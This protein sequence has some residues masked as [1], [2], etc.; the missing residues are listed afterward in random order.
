MSPLNLT[1]KRSI[2]HLVALQQMRKVAQ[3]QAD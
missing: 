2:S 3:V 1:I